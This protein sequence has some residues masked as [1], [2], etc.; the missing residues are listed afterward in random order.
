[1][2]RIHHY[3]L[4]TNFLWQISNPK[5]NDHIDWAVELIF[6]SDQTPKI[7][8]V[9]H[10]SR[11]EALGIKAPKFSYQIPTPQLEQRNFDA[12]LREM[13]KS[14]MEFFKGHVDLSESNIQ[15]KIID[16]RKYTHPKFIREGLFAKHIEIPESS[17]PAFRNNLCELLAVNALHAFDYPRE[18][19]EGVHVIHLLALFEE[20]KARRNINLLRCFRP[21]W[22]NRLKVKE[23]AK[24]SQAEISLYDEAV[25]LKP[26]AD[27][28]DLELMSFLILGFY[29]GA[30]QVPV[31]GFTSDKLIDRL[32]RRI[33]VFKGILASIQS[34]LFEQNQDISTLTSMPGILAK[35]DDAPE[36][37][38]FRLVGDVPS[39]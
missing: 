6:N 15:Q 3:F 1:M 35:Y 9:T 24:Y 34:F 33:Q 16:K 21:F 36:H 11:M 31:M 10:F 22:N 2:A 19:R 37:R 12:I 13:K 17:I 8:I 23:Q 29:D 4:D 20:I 38:E 18:V 14:A 28:V 32:Y 5:N 25:K 27:L 26:S 7:P 39:Y 30:R